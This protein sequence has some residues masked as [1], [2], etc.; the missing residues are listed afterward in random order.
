MNTGLQAKLE[1]KP[2]NAQYLGI[3]AKSAN[4]LFC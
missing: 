1:E 4:C 2:R 3:Y